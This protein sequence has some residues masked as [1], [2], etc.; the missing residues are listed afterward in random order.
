MR[1]VNSF[2][3]KKGVA[4][5]LDLLVLSAIVFLTSVTG[6][7]WVCA[8]TMQS[9]S[10]VRAMADTGTAKDGSEIVTNVS[11]TRLSGLIIH[12]AILGSLSFLPLLGKIPLPVVSGIF[13]YIG[14]KLM[15][16]NQFFDRLGY[17]FYEKSQLPSNRNSNIFMSVPSKT[18]G[19]FVG[20]QVFMVAFI[21]YLKQSKT[22]S[23][24]F[25]ACIAMLMLTR[26]IILPKIFSL[27]DLE[28][29]DSDFVIGQA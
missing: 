11:E 8:A 26:V 23:L 13:L 9:L 18:V 14:K 29:L 6:L 5:H 15:A 16:G 21:W 19:K 10:H 1:T 12:T 3:L 17:L 2:D 27:R 20:I 24:L 22:L 7:P 28:L 4:Y 25:P